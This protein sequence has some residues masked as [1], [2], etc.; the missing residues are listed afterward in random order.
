MLTIG[1][2]IIRYVCTWVT[3]TMDGH[4]STMDAHIEP[5]HVSTMDGHIQN[6]CMPSADVYIQ[7]VWS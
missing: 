2:Y 4:M 5:V 6:L 7:K 1:V 3:R